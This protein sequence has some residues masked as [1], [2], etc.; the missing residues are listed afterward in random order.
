VA[1]LEKANVA[2]TICDPEVNEPIPA[3]PIDPPTMSY[4]NYSKH[5]TFS[6]N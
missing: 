3:T 6:R 2:D 1:G 5:F 4:Y